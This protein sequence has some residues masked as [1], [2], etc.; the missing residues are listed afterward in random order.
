MNSPD[1]TR[2][3]PI[4]EAARHLGLSEDALR[5]YEREGLIGPL[6]RDAAGRRQ[7]S[8][9]DLAWVAVVICMRD[10]GLGITDLRRFTALL[11]RDDEPAE[12]I[13]FLQGR[14]AELGER[15]DALTRAMGILEEK[16]D[17]FGAR[18]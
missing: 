8:D 17:H 15:R 1:K 9:A 16:I 18:S 10:A 14:L 13:A 12:R 3:L 5:Y 4:G 2:P 7:Y 6:P 11:R